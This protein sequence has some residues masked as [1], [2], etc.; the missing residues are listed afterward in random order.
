MVAQRVINQLQRFTNCD[1]RE[2][3]KLISSDLFLLSHTVWVYSAVFGSPTLFHIGTRCIPTH[4]E[5]ASNAHGPQSPFPPPLLLLVPLS[6]YPNI[7]PLSPSSQFP[8]A[9]PFTLFLHHLL[10]FKRSE[11]RE[12]VGCGFWDIC[13]RGDRQSMAHS[14]AGPKVWLWRAVTWPMVHLSTLFGL[15]REARSNRVAGRLELKMVHLMEHL[16][17]EKGWK[18]CK[19]TKLGNKKGKIP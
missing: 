17:R 13:S 1:H 15:A 4:S 8:H 11:Q 9:A 18:Y 16:M 2:W 14:R 5:R 3:P 10:V 6:L 19:L 12:Y 7:L